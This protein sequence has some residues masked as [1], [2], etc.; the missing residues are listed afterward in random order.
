LTFAVDRSVF[1]NNYKGIYV[2]GV[3]SQVIQRNRFEVRKN[4]LLPFASNI[5]LHMINSTGYKVTENHF[6]EHAEGPTHGTTIGILVDNSGV[7]GN[8]IYK[9]TFEN[10]KIGGQSQNINSEPYVSVL[11]PNNI[12]LVWKCNNFQ[13]IGRADLGVSSGR[14]AYQQGHILSA[15]NPL[16]TKAAAGNIFSHSGNNPTNDFWAN[17]G[18]LDFNYAHH[19]NDFTTPYD[20]TSEII[21]PQIQTNGEILYSSASC[22]SIIKTILKP[23]KEILYELKT[24]LEEKES[25]IDGGNTEALIA[26]LS[27]STLSIG[28]KKDKVVA[29][30][31][32]LTDAVL[33]YY[34]ELNPPAGHVN[35]VVGLNSPVSA[36][37]WSIVEEMNL[38]KGIKRELEN[39]QSGISPL[40]ELRNE[41]HYEK[42]EYDLIVDELISFYLLDT[43]TVGAMDSVKFLYETEKTGVTRIKNLTS[44]YLTQGDFTNA[45]AMLDTYIAN[46]GED[47]YTKIVK[48]TIEAETTS[49]ATTYVAEEVSK[50]E[51]MEDIA[52][53]TNDKKNCY[54]AQ[55]LLEL[56]LAQEFDYEVEPL[57]EMMGSRSM[58][59]SMQTELLTTDEENEMIKLFPN[60]A[61]DEFFVVLDESS[62]NLAS[63]EITMYSFT[64]QQVKQV[65][66]TD[67]LQTIAVPVNDL[68]QG[69]YLVVVTLNGEV[70]SQQK[71]AIK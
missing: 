21:T 24:S 60:P 29:A 35:Q 68:S 50:K 40:T 28:E 3:A 2:T 20:Y 17:P 70:V 65:Q 37:I 64:G 16:A 71:M 55:A 38:P 44:W 13:N 23:S 8:L 43:V 41:Y 45:Q 26:Q 62:E 15:T 10:L 36:E 5:G 18:V 42:G 46:Y 30:S 27:N 48:Y 69:M 67:R 56:A 49:C 1:T 32:Y 12:G 7:E 33:K 47:N 52:H 19:N 53:Q 9:N 54:R 59:T 39:L 34:L 66:S 22:P 57:I 6:E 4:A 51:M 31:P 11:K 25:K 58:Q 61:K 63:V 14:I